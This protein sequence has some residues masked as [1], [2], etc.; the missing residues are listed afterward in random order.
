MRNKSC[1]EPGQYENHVE[2]GQTDEDA[3]GG[4]LHLGSTENE[5]GE[6]IA[7]QSESADHV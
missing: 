5:N 6:E 1:V 7:H 2:R 4:A 3:I